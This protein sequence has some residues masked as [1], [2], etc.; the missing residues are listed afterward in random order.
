MLL[1]DH[2]DPSGVEGVC[3]Y[4]LVRVEFHHHLDIGGKGCINSSRLRNVRPLLEAAGRDSFVHTNGMQTKVSQPGARRLG[5]SGFSDKHSSPLVHR[6]ATPPRNTFAHTTV[7]STDRAPSMWFG[8][9]FIRWRMLRC[10]NFSTI[11]EIR[12]PSC[13]G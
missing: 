7:P 2:S 8:V 5:R 11:I 1:A 13:Q 3:V 10:P 6:L 9:G 12:L 4:Q